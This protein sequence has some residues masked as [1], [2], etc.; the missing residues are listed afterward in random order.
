MISDMTLYNIYY[1]HTHTHTCVCAKLLQSYL[2][3]CNHMDHSPPGSSVHEI[4]QA[5]ILE[6]VAISSCWRFSQP[7]DRT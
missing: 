1:T 7:K 5:R 2:T 6:W 3:L 4:S